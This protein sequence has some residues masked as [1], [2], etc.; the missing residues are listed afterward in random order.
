[1]TTALPPKELHNKGR[2]GRPPGSAKPP[3]SPWHLETGQRITVRRLD[4]G[5]S[6]FDLADK[7]G[8]RQISIS[9]YENGLIDMGI[10]RLIHIAVALETTTDTILGLRS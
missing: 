6:Q 2:I 10:A 4:M 5:M 3:R 1:M 8:C 9:H 7:V